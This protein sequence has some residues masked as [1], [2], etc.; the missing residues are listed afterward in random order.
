MIDACNFTDGNFS[1]SCLPCR[2]NYSDVLLDI[3]NCSDL[4][5]TT[6]RCVTFCD[7]FPRVL[8][9]VYLILSLVSASCCAVVFLTY[10]SFPRLK[11]F[12]SK[13]FLYR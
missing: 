2:S 1:Y 3:K 7:A 9:Y 10:F 11:G 4:A 12:S 8:P 5:N 13:I 6:T